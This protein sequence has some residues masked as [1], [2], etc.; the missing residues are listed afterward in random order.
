MNLNVAQ[1]KLLSQLKNPVKFWLFTFMKVPAARIAGLK[2][3]HIDAETCTTSIPFKFLN[4]NPFKSIYFAV[5]S[6]AA[7]F[8]TAALALL[9]LK[10]YAS[11]VAFIVVKIEG[12]FTK[13]ASD[14]TYFTCED[15]DKY[16]EAIKKTV[17][18]G[19]AVEVRAKTVGRIKDGT[20]V[21][22]FYFTWSFK[23]RS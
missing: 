12:D 13:K 8:S 21:A 7:E 6:M 16:R 2:M 14:I 22:I 15:G 11:S 4:K 1:K 5:Q 20:E 19:K 18:T 9:E 17:E 3:V 23:K 10:R